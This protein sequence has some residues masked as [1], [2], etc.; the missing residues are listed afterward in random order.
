MY[1]ISLQ[2]HGN[3]QKENE[4][5]QK[6]LDVKAFYTKIEKLQGCDKTKAIPLKTVNCGTMTRN[7]TGQTKSYCSRFIYTCPFQH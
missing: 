7:Y 1:Y 6:T 4:D 5:L 3:L 2:V